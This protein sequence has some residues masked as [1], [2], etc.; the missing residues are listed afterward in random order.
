MDDVVAKLVSLV[1]SGQRWERRSA[2]GATAIR[3]TANDGTHDDTAVT[4][5]QEAE[6]L[7]AVGGSVRISL[8]PKK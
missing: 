1:K 6:F 8:P 4:A 3:L 7:N 2:D 5:E